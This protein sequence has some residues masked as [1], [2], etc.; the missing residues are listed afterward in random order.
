M[1]SER[2][3]GLSPCRTGPWGDKAITTGFK[4]ILL[5]EVHRLKYHIVS[6]IH[7]HIRR[8]KSHAHKPR[9]DIVTMTTEPTDWSCGEKLAYQLLTYRQD[10]KIF[11]SASMEKYTRRRIAN[12]AV[13]HLLMMMMLLHLKKSFTEIEKANKLS[14]R[15]FTV[16]HISLERSE[17][18]EDI[19]G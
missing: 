10:C 9:L 8:Q 3:Y 12:C 17:R 7:K 16:T 6:S 4:W 14:P 19:I 18:N 2:T 15:S 5:W 11:Y 13:C 1:S